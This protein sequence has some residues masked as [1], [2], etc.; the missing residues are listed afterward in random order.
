[1]RIKKYLNKNTLLSILLIG[2]STGLANAAPVTIPNSFN[3]GTPAVAAEVNGNFDAV[4]T[5]VDDNDNRVTTNTTSIETTTLNIAS[6]TATL[7]ALQDRVTA[8]EADA[9][10]LQ[11]DNAAL[12]ERVVTLETDNASLEN[13]ISNVVPY[14]TGGTD[15]QDQPTIFFSGVNVHVNN[16]M[17]STT[18]VNATGNVIIGYDEGLTASHDFCTVVDNIQSAYLEQI[19]CENNN[20]I[21]GAGPQKIGS[22]NLVIGY[23]HNY[24][25]SAGLIAG[26]QNT[27]TGANSVVSG[28]ASNYA[29]GQGSSV[30]GGI[31]NT[32]NGETSSVS[33]GAR[34]EA[35]AIDDWA[36]GS[37]LEDN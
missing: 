1:M 12:K 2:L 33:G 34:R 13:L 7:N 17:S 20:G 11:A 14:M 15:A 35:S 36:A 3:A 23:G 8:L 4:K 16:G 21:W 28:G 6:L 9:V 32:A 27:V 37:L 24:T 5:A 18:S 19:E 22:H 29:Q 10:T 30:S 31:E 25:Q 26:F